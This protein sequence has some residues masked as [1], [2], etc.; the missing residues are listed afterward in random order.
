MNIKKKKT[1]NTFISKIDH[2]KWFIAFFIFFTTIFANVYYKLKYSLEIRFIFTIINLV[3]IYYIVLKTKKGKYI[4]SFIKSSIF[5]MQKV[6]WPSKE[7]AFQTTFVVIV[8]IALIS[9]ILWVVDS[10]F[11]YIVALLIFR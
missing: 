1:V 4:Y 8:L 10:L 3:I 6:R 11:S 5:E 9:L 7:D 2:I